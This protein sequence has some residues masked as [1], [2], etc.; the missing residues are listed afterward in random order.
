M[1][2]PLDVTI[3]KGRRVIVQTFGKITLVRDPKTGRFRKHCDPQSLV[4]G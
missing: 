2:A 1:P 3:R 4:V